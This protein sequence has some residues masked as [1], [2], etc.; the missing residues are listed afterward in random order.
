MWR[1]FLLPM[2]SRSNV[3]RHNHTQIIWHK[4]ELKVLILAV[5][6]CVTC[7]VWS[8]TIRKFEKNQYSSG[9]SIML[10]GSIIEFD[11]VH[12]KAFHCGHLCGWGT[13]TDDHPQSVMLTLNLLLIYQWL[14]HAISTLIS[15]STPQSDMQNGLVRDLCPWP[16]SNKKFF[17]TFPGCG[18]EF[19]RSGTLKRH[20]RMHTGKNTFYT[21]GI[22]RLIKTYWTYFTY[23]VKKKCS[24]LSSQYL[25]ARWPYKYKA[26]HPQ[27]GVREYIPQPKLCVQMKD[28]NV[29][30]RCGLILLLYLEL[31]GPDRSLAIMHL[32]QNLGGLAFWTG[33][34]R[35]LS[36]LVRLKFRC[37]HDSQIFIN[38]KSLAGHE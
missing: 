16:V 2:K 24:V 31:N 25:E 28:R 26:H 23:S 34:Y 12:Q 37:Y 6:S 22:I 1:N 4:V 13:G 7:R 32:C 27:F 35:C 33:K 19:N 30:P 21:T 14:Y 5:K 17:C 11:G 9:D 18:K 3:Q 29:D 36:H 38:H 15:E 10:H 20:F 8:D